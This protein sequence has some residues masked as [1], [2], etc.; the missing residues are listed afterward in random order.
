QPQANYAMGKAKMFN[1]EALEQSVDPL[2]LAT[3]STTEASGPPGPVRDKWA[4][5]VGV[6][7]FQDSHLNLQYTTKDAKDFAALLVDPNYGRFQK[8][9]VYV[10]LDQ[11]A[12]T[13]KVKSEL[14]LIARSAGRDDLVLIYLA[15]H[16][17]ARESDICGANYVIT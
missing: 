5:I 2:V 9:H 17:S 15:S 13:R 7:K 8:D 4:L 10:L 11:N 16:G 1:A 12:T 14:N 6:G 3:A